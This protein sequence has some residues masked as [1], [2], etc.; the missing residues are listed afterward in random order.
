MG[1][2]R[3]FDPEVALTR[4]LRIFWQQ[5]YRATSLP[6]LETAMA[7]GRTSIYGAFGD[8]EALFLAA[9]D[10]YAARHMQPALDALVAAPNIRAA[11]R[12]HFKAL[13]AFFSDPTL[14]LGCLLTNVATECDRGASPIGRKLAALIGRNENAFYK[15]LRAAQARGE[16]GAS[17]DVRAV[18]RYFAMTIQ[19]L[20]VLA[21]AY[22]D[23]ALLHD[24]VERMF[25]TLDAF[26]GPEPVRLSTPPATL[27]ES[28]PPRRARGQR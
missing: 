2:P 4:A 5:G 8:K 13:L 15:A 20:S 11:I 18:A 28:P 7:I 17:I 25:A 27:E 6:D 16:V 12:A 14:P 26:L 10:L 21:K 24:V 23:Q 9:L 22:A 3:E 19:G 1:R